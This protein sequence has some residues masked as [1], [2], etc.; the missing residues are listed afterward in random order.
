MSVLA[1]VLVLVLEERGNKEPKEGE[2]KRQ[3]IV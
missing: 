3:L 2:S 1:W